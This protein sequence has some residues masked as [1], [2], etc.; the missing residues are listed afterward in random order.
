MDD[1]FD[2]QQ[3][4]HCCD[5][6]GLEYGECEECVE[7]DARGDQ[8]QRIAP[9]TTELRLVIPEKLCSEHLML[10]EEPLE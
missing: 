2:H 10:Y 7:S 6:Q 5:D 3:L 4:V 8:K 1:V 9:S